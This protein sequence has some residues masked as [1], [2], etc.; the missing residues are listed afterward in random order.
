MPDLTEIIPLFSN[1]GGKRTFTQRNVT[2]IRLVQC[3][4]E[5]EDLSFILTSSNNNDIASKGFLSLF[6]LTISSLVLIQLASYL[7]MMCIS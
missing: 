7:V 3:N 1:K 5:R 2:T 4:F 6:E